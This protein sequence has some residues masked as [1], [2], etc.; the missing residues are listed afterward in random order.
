M[1]KKV[2]RIKEL[3]QE[4]NIKQ[5]EIAKIAGV[6]A[7][8][9]SRWENGESHIKTSKA[10][11]LAVYFGVGVAYLLGYDD[12]DKLITYGSKEFSNGV[13]LLDEAIKSQIIAYNETYEQTLQLIDDLKKVF[14]DSDLEEAVLLIE[15]LIKDLD[16]YTQKTLELQKRALEISQL[17]KQFERLEDK[18]KNTL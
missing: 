10:E 4:K 18:R 9:I 5:E 11:K 17:K 1:F 6:S 12:I 14:V 3:R 15:K 13:T 7:M 16:S 8:T 2:N